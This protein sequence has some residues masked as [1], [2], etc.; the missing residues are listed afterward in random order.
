LGKRVGQLIPFGLQ[1]LGLLSNAG[2]KLLF[3]GSSL[4]G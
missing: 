1:G 2:E 3:V 4:C